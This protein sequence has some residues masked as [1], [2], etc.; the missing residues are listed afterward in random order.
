[1]LAQAPNC[2]FDVVDFE[3][4]AIPPTRLWQRA[5]RHRLPASGTAAWSAQHE[6]Q[7]AMGEHREAGCR[8]H[9]LVEPEFSTVEVDRGVDVVDDVADAYLGHCVSSRWLT[10]RAYVGDV[11]QDG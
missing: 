10:R 6:A 7:V 8:V 5:I 9:V 2:G 3:L 4:E 11:G 1:V